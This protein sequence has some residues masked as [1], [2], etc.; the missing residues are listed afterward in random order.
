MTGQRQTPRQGSDQSATRAPHS[1]TEV[2]KGLRQTA[3]GARTLQQLVTRSLDAESEPHIED[4]LP[5]EFVGRDELIPDGFTLDDDPDAPAG[6]DHAELDEDEVAPDMPLDRVYPARQ[7][8]IFDAGRSEPSWMVLGSSRFARRLGTGTSAQIWEHRWR[9][10]DNLGRGLVELIGPAL[11]SPTRWQLA[12]RLPPVGKL[13]LTRYLQFRSVDTLQP[14]VDRRTREELERVPT[15]DQLRDGQLVLCPDWY[16]TGSEGIDNPQYLSYSLAE[17]WEPAGLSFSNELLSRGAIALGQLELPSGVQYIETVLP[18]QADLAGLARTWRRFLLSPPQDDVDALTRS[19]ARE[20]SGETKQQGRTR[21]AL[22]GMS[23]WRDLI[24]ATLEEKECWAT[25]EL[26]TTLSAR[27]G[28]V[29][30]LGGRA[31]WYT[32]LCLLG[33]DAYKAGDE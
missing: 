11:I 23:R 21:N 25:A 7:L 4:D 5:P 1:T 14:K 30:P 2:V 33:P 9:I 8:C 12:Q 31:Y 28:T 26:R 13:G 3:L 18:N 27:T 10:L 17:R 22:A 32:L 20:E 24:T 16:P 15:T 19:V 6:F 29:D